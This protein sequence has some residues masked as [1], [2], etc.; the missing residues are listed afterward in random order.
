M[1]NTIPELVFSFFQLLNLK[2]VEIRKG[3]YQVQ[4]DDQLAKELDGWRAKGRLFQ[5]TFDRKL[6][7][8]FGAEL[9]SP[10]SYRLDT[11]IRVLQKQAVLSVGYLPHDVFYEP[12][13]RMKVLDR[14]K[15]QN[16][17][18]RF[19][20]ID[21]RLRYGPY[22]WITLRVTYL[23]YEKSEELRKALIDL[24]SGKV[25][26]YEIPAELLKPG[27]C[28][29]ML[30]YRRRLSFKQAYQNLQQEIIK[31][32][33]YQDPAWALTAARDLAQEQAKLEEYFRDLPD[34]KQRKLRIQELMDRAR[35]RVQV[36]PLRAAIL[37]LPKF[38][39]RIMQV[40]TSEKINRITYDPVSSQH[41]PS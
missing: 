16:P 29:P 18:S 5:F 17:E 19:Y 15:L 1:P 2:P 4:I 27:F 11:I 12:A 28:D 23:A 36:R 14:L 34:P 26:N 22:F 10:G 39:Y 6:A 38:E 3:I 13:V 32:L 33:E 7:Q 21:H 20:V 41:E 40:D 35:P 31:E 30:Q 24:I 25:V 9:I 37:Y 8:S